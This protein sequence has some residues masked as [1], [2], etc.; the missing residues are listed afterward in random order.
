MRSQKNIDIKSNNKSF[1]L[2]FSII[3]FVLSVIV[4]L[5]TKIY[6]SLFFII[7]SIYFLCAAYFFPNRLSLLNSIWFKFGIFLS[8]IINPIVLGFIFYFLLSP[9]AIFTRILGRDELSISKN[10]IKKTSFWIIRK[11]IAI[12]FK[13]QF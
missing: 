6:F 9:I 4:F 3:F 13:N 8:K 12:N 5:Y 1:G 10:N 11:D 2:I 7:L